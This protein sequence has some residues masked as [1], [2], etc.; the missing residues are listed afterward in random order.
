MLTSEQFHERME[1]VGQRI[2]ELSAH[3]E[4]PTSLAAVDLLAT[5][6][7]LHGA[8]LQRML[9]LVKAGGAAYRPLL[10]KFAQ[11]DLIRSLLLYH[12]LHPVDVQSRLEEV[13]DAFRPLVAGY[14]GSL[15]LTDVSSERVTIRLQMDRPRS[16]SPVAMV[17]E[18]LTNAVLVAAPDVAEVRFNDETPSDLPIVQLPIG[19]ASPSKMRSS[20]P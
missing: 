2:A 8:G 10:E 20:V 19:H 6:G 14:G 3:P 5:F 17:K 16:G 4:D 1:R 13:V 11:D 18:L 12:D 15:S 9:A 7:N